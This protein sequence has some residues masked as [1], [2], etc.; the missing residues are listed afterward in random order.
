MLYS[1]LTSSRRK[2]IGVGSFLC[3]DW[4]L[5]HGLGVGDVLG[6]SVDWVGKKDLGVI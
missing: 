3:F 6:L 1:H 2:M 4:I 5:D